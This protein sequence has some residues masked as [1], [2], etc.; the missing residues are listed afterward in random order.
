MSAD[1]ATFTTGDEKEAKQAAEQIMAQSG[2]LPESGANRQK[3]LAL[4]AE[5]LIAAAEELLAKIDITPAS[6]DAL[7]IDREVRAA[8]N[9]MNEVYVSNAQSD[10]TYAWIYRDPHND[11]GGRYVRRMQA[12]GWERVLGDDPEAKEHKHVE[13][14]V[15]ADTL[16][17]RIRLDRKLLLDKRDRLLR[18]AQQAGITARVYDLAERAG[19]RMLDTTELLGLQGET[20]TD[21]ATANRRAAARN[22]F[23]RMNVGGKMDRMLQEGRI[24]GIPSPGRSR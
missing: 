8:L 19:T 17:M 18:E 10:Y 15:V 13:G 21:H 14:R 6:T 2:E 9:E 1:K 23:H 22:R 24:P 11:F 3:E 7:E 4:K 5:R 16:L 20:I 12:L